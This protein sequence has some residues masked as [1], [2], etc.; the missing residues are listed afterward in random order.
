MEKEQLS[1]CSG[2]GEQRSQHGAVLPL[3]PAAFF[4]KEILLLLGCCCLIL[5]VL[6]ID[7]LPPFPRALYECAFTISDFYLLHLFFSTSA[8][9]T[10]KWK[11]DC[12]QRLTFSLPDAF[13]PV[14]VVSGRYQVCS[15]HRKML[16][17]QHICFLPS[18]FFFWSLH[19]GSTHT[20]KTR[21]VSGGCSSI[22]LLLL[23]PQSSRVSR[24]PG[25]SRAG[26]V[27]CW[28]S[29][30]PC[31]FPA[32]PWAPSPGSA[33]CNAV[34]SQVISPMMRWC[35]CLGERAERPGREYKCTARCTPVLGASAAVSEPWSCAFRCV[36]QTLLLRAFVFVLFLPCC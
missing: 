8:P 16:C 17:Y 34:C 12:E 26:H 15:G 14:F 20:A 6:V 18:L 19:S 1:L 36:S 13:F 29:F 10:S 28:C 5:S 2:W 24:Q 31:C 30:A 7:F 35:L 32:S 22:V 4:P 3:H 23:T 21:A 9:F 27:W 11:L 25:M 33:G